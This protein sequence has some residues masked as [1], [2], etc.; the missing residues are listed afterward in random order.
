V[1]YRNDLVCRL[2]N[3]FGEKKSGGKREIIAGRSHRNGDGLMPDFS[4]FGKSKTNFKRFFDG[5]RVRLNRRKIGS[6]NAPNLGGK[7]FS[8]YAA[9]RFRHK[10]IIAKLF[11]VPFAGG[12][13]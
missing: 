2:Q 3:S 11:K 7:F 6:R 10:R 12:F 5:E 9:R 13:R 1:F 8:F 4:V